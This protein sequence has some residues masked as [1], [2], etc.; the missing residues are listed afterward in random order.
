MFTWNNRACEGWNEFNL[1]KIIKYGRLVKQIRLYLYV[2]L[3]GIV[4]L[5]ISN[6]NIGWSVNMEHV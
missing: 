3:V 1:R 6:I 2:S 5:C 4:I